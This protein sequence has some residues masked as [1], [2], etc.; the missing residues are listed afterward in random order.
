VPQAWGTDDVVRKGGD[1]FKAKHS[2]RPW[3]DAV[4]AAPARSAV[5]AVAA[6][7]ARSAV[8]AVAV[9]AVAVAVASRGAH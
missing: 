8:P 5:P 9:P 3:V 7:P 1:Y 2:P 6:A 4:A